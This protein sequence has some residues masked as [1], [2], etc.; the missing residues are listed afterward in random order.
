MLK[1]V[2]HSRAR[3]G[4]CQILPAC[5]VLAAAAFA[6]GTGAAQ[7]SNVDGFLK[8]FTATGKTNLIF[9]VM[10]DCPVSN[11]YAPDIQR[12]CR[13]YQGQAVRC[14]LVYEDWNADP[15]AIQSS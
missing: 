11:S 6:A 7:V 4:R 8:L 13:A 3:A 2:T 14:S 15:A 5:A 9:F 1:K 12:I 10:S